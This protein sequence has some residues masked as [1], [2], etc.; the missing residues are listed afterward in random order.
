MTEPTGSATAVPATQ[1]GSFRIYRHLIIGFVIALIAPFT[2]LA[3]PFAILL[4]IVIGRDDVERRQGIQRSAASTIVGILAV[5]GGVLATI[6]FGAVIG[7]VIALPIIVLAAFSERAAADGTPVDRVMARLVLFLMPILA[8]I[9]LIAI[10][11]SINIK[12]GA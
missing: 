7:A 1:A 11:A 4:G 12:V 8:Y 6:L 9:V 5:A 3:W 2:G 10:G